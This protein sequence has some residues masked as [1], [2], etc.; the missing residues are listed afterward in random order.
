MP[1]DLSQVELAGE[2]VVL[3]L[4]A[5]LI[6]FQPMEPAGRRRPLVYEHGHEIGRSPFMDWLVDCVLIFAID[7]AIDGVN[8]PVAQTRSRAD[9]ERCGENPLAAGC[10][11]RI[12]RV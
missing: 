1:A 3:I 11:D 6:R 9:K 2:H 12:D 5:E 10:K 4:A 7:A 8:Q